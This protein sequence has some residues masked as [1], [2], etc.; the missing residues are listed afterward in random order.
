[1]WGPDEKIVLSGWFVAGLE[2]TESSEAVMKAQVL[3]LRRVPPEL[4]VTLDN[5][6]L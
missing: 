5:S 4:K 1:M 6:A 2:G 3:N